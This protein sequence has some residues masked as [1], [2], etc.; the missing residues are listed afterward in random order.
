MTPVQ[1]PL[2]VTLLAILHVLQAAVVFLIGLVLMILG[3]LIRSMMRVYYPRLFAGILP[4]IGVL[5][6]ILGLLYIGFAYGLWTGKG[7]AWTLS[8]IF[9]VLGIIGSLVSLVR[10]GFV[11]I[12]TLVLDVVIIYYLTRPHIK[13][14]FGKGLP[15]TTLSSPPA[16]QAAGSAQSTAGKYCSNCGAPLTMDEKFCSH[17]GT[18]IL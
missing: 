15:V 3:T 7:W 10:G 13:V 5:L 18:R 6:I 1:R 16:A 9:A 17:C 2:G 14:F 12:V 11:S 8:L 4:I